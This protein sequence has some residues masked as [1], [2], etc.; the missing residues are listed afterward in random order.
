M[1]QIDPSSSV[2]IKKNNP[3]GAEVITVKT[4]I[5]VTAGKTSRG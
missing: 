1:I 5:A 4:E 3:F 2:G